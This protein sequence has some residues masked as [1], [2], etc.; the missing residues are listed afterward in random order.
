MNPDELCGAIVTDFDDLLEIVDGVLARPTF[1]DRRKSIRR[2]CIDEYWRGVEHLDRQET[3]TGIRRRTSTD[4]EFRMALEYA[5]GVDTANT[6]RFIYGKQGH[7]DARK[8]TAASE[9]LRRKERDLA[10]RELRPLFGFAYSAIGA[11]Q[12]FAAAAHGEGNGARLRPVLCMDWMPTVEGRVVNSLTIQ[13]AAMLF[14]LCNDR[15]I[16]NDFAQSIVRN[17]NEKLD[18]SSCKAIDRWSQHFA[19]NVHVRRGFEVLARD[20]GERLRFI[21]VTRE[22]FHWPAMIAYRAIEP[23]VKYL[24]R[25]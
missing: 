14:A 23:I 13:Q 18:R 1:I 16:Q 9:C 25:D 10:P 22:M 15:R 19:G 4:R 21:A 12:E 5:F 24:A 6:I 2:L 3:L 8:W 17:D 11:S 7:N 20:A